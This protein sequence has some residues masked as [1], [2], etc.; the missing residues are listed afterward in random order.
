MRRQGGSGERLFSS[1]AS[2][3]TLLWGDTEPK[4]DFSLFG[5][6]SVRFRRKFGSGHGVY[7]RTPFALSPP[8]KTLSDFL[9]LVKRFG[10]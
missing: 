3:L 7:G 1:V 9:P 8:Q 6:R 5:T 4:E 2:H 10:N